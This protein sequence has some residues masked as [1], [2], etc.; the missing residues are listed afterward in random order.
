MGSD[1]FRVCV[2]KHDLTKRHRHEAQA[3]GTG[4]S[5]RTD[6]TTTTLGVTRHVTRSM[7]EYYAHPRCTSSHI[8][9]GIPYCTLAAR[10]APESPVTSLHDGH[11]A[12][13]DIGTLPSYGTFDWSCAAGPDTRPANSAHSWTGK[14]DQLFHLAMAFASAP[15]SRPMD[16]GVADLILIVRSCRSRP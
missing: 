8:N 15:A 10:R 11:Q 3:R 1:S 2:A 14:N 6:L 5:L 13:H 7:A 9:S 12:R 4:H 16:D